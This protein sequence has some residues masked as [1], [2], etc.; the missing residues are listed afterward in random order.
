MLHFKD[1]PAAAAAEAAKQEIKRKLQA[2]TEENKRLTQQVRATRL[3]HYLLGVF[4]CLVCFNS[5]VTKTNEG[6][7]GHL[8]F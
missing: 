8:L 4:M 5:W 2:L 7:E 3:L 1:N 6:H